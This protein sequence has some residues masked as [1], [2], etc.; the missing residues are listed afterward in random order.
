MR[1]AALHRP[2]TEPVRAVDAAGQSGTRI[3]ILPGL[4]VPY[5]ESVVIDESLQLDVVGSVPGIVVDGGGGPAFTV[6]STQGSAMQFRDL[7]LRGQ[8][9]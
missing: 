5:A 2:C 8:T 3:E 1:H 6:L 9:G 7:I 4:G